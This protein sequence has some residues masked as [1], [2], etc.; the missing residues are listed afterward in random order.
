MVVAE[1][2][3]G[4][5]CG[6]PQAPCR[7]ADAR[8]LEIAR[9][10]YERMYRQAGGIATGSRVHAFLQ[11]Q[12]HLIDNLPCNAA[13]R[14]VHRAL[15]GVVAIAGICSY[16]SQLPQ[17]ATASFQQALRFAEAS[18][19]RAF[20]AYVRGLL[21]NQLLLLEKNGQ[22][23]TLAESAIRAADPCLSRALRA[24][25]RALQAKA[26]ARL[27][28]RRE[29]R[30]VMRLAEA[31]DASIKPAA[32]PPETGYIQPGLIEEHLAEALL[33]MGDVHAARA[34][35]EGF[36]GATTHPRG[37]ANRLIVLTH[38]AMA[39]GDFDEAAATTRR[40]LDAAEGMES[41]RFRDRLIAIRQS[42]RQHRSSAAVRE[43]AEELDARLALPL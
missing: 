39:G 27:T 19:D 24:D 41:Q 28:D 13:G 2:D 43:V 36:A 6:S 30:R 16:D 23:A 42:L 8:R 7:N 12:T 10:H 4:P 38:I 35:A 18:G 25:L 32:E 40:L 22:A 31:A 20:A 34:C 17:A 21:T 29:A 14:E 15:G 11:A 5:W 3:D 26:F 33:T 37:R 1:S 9:R